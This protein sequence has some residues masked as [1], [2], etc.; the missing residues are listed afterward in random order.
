[1]LTCLHLAKITTQEYGSFHFG[2]T[3]LLE[4]N[5]LCIFSELS[6]VTEQV[7]IN[8]G[9]LQVNFNRFVWFIAVTLPKLHLVHAS[10]VNANKL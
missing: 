6:L 5:S 8:S 1:M 9:R 10:S 3:F 4:L 7:C 2:F